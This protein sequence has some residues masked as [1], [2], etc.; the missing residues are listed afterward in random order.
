ML[1]AE[2]IGREKFCRSAVAET[3]RELGPI[4]ILVNNA[5]EQ[6]PQDKGRD[7]GVY[8]FALAG[9]GGQ[10]DSGE[11]RGARTNLDAA[12]SFDVSGERGGDFRLR[13]SVG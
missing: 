5:A 6:H 7:R 1:I 2:D 8:S 12:N 13:H 10:K 3:K 4:D 11:C 9:V